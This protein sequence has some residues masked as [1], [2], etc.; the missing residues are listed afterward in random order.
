MCTKNCRKTV[1]ARILTKNL[2]YSDPKRGASSDAQ[3]NSHWHWA[4]ARFAF[5]AGVKVPSSLPSSGSLSA[6]NLNQGVANEHVT[7]ARVVDKDTLNLRLPSGEE[8]T[9]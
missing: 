5:A 9:V 7:A 6:K 3:S 4:R 8:L 2:H 1:W